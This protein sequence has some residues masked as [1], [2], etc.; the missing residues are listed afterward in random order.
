MKRFGSAHISRIIIGYLISL[1]V[2]FGGLLI[3]TAL[4]LNGKI[5]EIKS[6]LFM[7]A[8]MAMATGAGSAAARQAE[9]RQRIAHGIIIC[10]SVLLTFAL[11]GMLFWEGESSMVAWMLIAAVLGSGIMI[12]VSFACKNTKRRKWR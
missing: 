11:S 3:V 5:D 1:V 4:V 9:G 12:A 6:Y 10:A 7:P 2:A 8:V